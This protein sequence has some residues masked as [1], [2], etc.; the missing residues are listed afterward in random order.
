MSFRTGLAEPLLLG[1]VT[2][3][4]RVFVAP[5]SGITDM[6]FRRRAHAAGAGMVVSEMVASGELTKGRQGSLQRIRPAGLDVHV[7]QLAGREAQP[8]AEAARIAAGEGADIIDINMGCPAKKVTGG[9][10]GSAL[11]RDLDHAVTL[12]AAV[13]GAVAVPVTVKMRLGW[14]ETALN[15]PMLARRAEQAGVR[16]IT[17]H[18]RTRCQFYTGQADWRAIRRVK[19][20]VTIPVVA[21]GDISSQADAQRAL[22]LSGAG[23][24][25]M[26]GAIASADGPGASVKPDDI[27]TYVVEHYEEMLSF[28][29]VAS[30]LRQ[31]RKHLGWYLDGHAPDVAANVR[32]AILRADDPQTVVDLLRRAL[33]HVGQ[34]Q[35]S[36]A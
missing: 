17:V 30:G 14:D 23:A 7:V 6:P 4:N 28:Y 13:V 5:M 12:I 11:M 8:L 34:M 25:W 18:G 24:P 22:A 9:Y 10:A 32:A 1:R 16:M 36:A 21:N 20:A 3:R 31:A 29:G 15:A 2:L 35:R 27:A 33:D 26:A 19:E